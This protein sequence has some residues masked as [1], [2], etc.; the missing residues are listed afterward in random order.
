MNVFMDGRLADTPDPWRVFLVAFGLLEL[1][2]EP[3]F[4]AVYV[5]VALWMLWHLREGA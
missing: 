4:Q 2:F 1:G 5:V 3:Y